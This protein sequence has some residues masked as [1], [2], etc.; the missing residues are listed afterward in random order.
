MLGGGVAALTLPR[1]PPVEMPLGR[2]PSTAELLPWA[3]PDASPNPPKPAGLPAEPSTVLG[4]VSALA[5][6]AGSG[7]GS[8]LHPE[9]LTSADLETAGGAA[10]PA[11]SGL[12]VM[13]EPEM[14]D[15]D[16]AAERARVLGGGAACDAIALR[17]L[18][19][20]FPGPPPKVAVAD[21]CLGIRAGERFGLLGDNGGGSRPSACVTLPHPPTGLQPVTWVLS[22]S[23]SATAGL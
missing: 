3:A 13:E 18:R 23:T 12:G 21:L 6:G 15:E 20:V 4:C 22:C 17:R 14:E 16:V 8:G 5:T 2:P 1:P 7:S 10:D 9:R 11:G 19:K